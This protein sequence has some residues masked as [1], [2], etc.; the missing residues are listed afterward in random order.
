MLTDDTSMLEEEDLICD[1]EHNMKSESNSRS[2]IINTDSDYK[3]VN[4][5]FESIQS[6]QSGVYQKKTLNRSKK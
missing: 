3:E 1:V 2:K 6:N 5:T 4:K